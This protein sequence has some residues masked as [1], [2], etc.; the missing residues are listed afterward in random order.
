MLI[1]FKNAWM[2]LDDIH[3]VQHTSSDGCIRIFMKTGDKEAF[4]IV[5]PR[6]E[7]EEFVERVNTAR[8]DRLIPC[9]K[10]ACR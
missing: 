2:D 6:E 7:A 5:G 1:Q 9:S 4:T 3:C 10:G 8:Q